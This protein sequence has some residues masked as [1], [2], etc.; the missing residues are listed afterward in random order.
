MH[1][2]RKL[3]TPV[4]HWL[5]LLQLAP[6]RRQQSPQSIVQL[7]QVSLPLHE[8][9]PQKVWG[10]Q[11]PATQRPELHTELVEHGVPFGRLLAQIPKLQ[12]PEAQSAFPRQGVPALQRWQSAWQERGFGEPQVSVPS[13]KPS[14]QSWMQ[15]PA[16]Q[17]MLRHALLVVHGE[18]AGRFPPMQ[19]PKLQTPLAQSAFDVQTASAQGRQERSG[20]NDWLG[21][22]ASPC[23][24]WI[25]R[26]R[27]R[28]RAAAA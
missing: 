24:C 7:E 6:R 12:P 25:R 11:M 19:K 26:T 16:V 5:P 14:P 3:Q 17:S 10:A 18:P 9:S 8:R 13:Q 2:P 23:L 1:A 22:V 4:Q 20:P 28:S 15:R 27:A 21:A